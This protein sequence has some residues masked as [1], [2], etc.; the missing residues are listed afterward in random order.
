MKVS[1]Y[2]SY[3]EVTYSQ[4]AIRNAIDNDPSPEQLELIKEWAENLFDPLREWVGGPVKLNSVFRSAD[5]NKKIGGSQSSQ[6]SVGLDPSKNS[7]GAAGDIDDTY[8]KKPNRDMFHYIKDK[9]DFD[10][11]IWEFG[12]SRNPNWVHASY[13]PDGKNRK[14]VLIAYRSGGKVKYVPLEGNEHRIS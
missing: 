7:Y 11:L 3:D 5:L 10:Q 6:H 13:R 4:T 2:V 12:D 1:K 14:Q 8:G 9:L